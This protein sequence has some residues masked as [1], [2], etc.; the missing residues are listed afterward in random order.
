MNGRI[1][2]MKLHLPLAWPASPPSHAGV[3]LRPFRDSD[4]HLAAELTQ[5]P[6]IQL[7]STIPARPTAEEA[8][9]WILHQNG[10]FT[11]GMGYSFAIADAATDRALGQIGMWLKAVETGRAT[12]GYLVAPPARGRG[13]G[14]AALCALTAFAWTLPVLH[15]VELYIEPWNTGSIRTAEAAGYQR[16]GLLRSHQS[17]GG[18]RRDMLLYAAIRP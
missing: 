14:A 12:A 18:E 5:D 13:V 6:Y 15:R 9:E 2:L 16:E 17:I 7:I 8:M 3:V 11:E 10:R 4:A 1:A